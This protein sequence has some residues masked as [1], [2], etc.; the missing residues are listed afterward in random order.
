MCNLTILGRFSADVNG[1]TYYF[2]NDMEAQANFQ[3]ADGAF[4][5]NRI[6]EVVWT[7]Y[8]TEGN[9]ERIPLNKESFELVYISHLA[10]VQN[11]IAKFRDF[12]MPLVESSTTVEELESIVW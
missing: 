12:L 5:K 9:V 4:E 7:A 11:S 1:S 10:H 3:K 2:S 8:N 6:I